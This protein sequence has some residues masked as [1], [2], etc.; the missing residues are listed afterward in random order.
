MWKLVLAQLL[1]AVTPVLLS[2]VKGFAVTFRDK[3]RKTDNP[4]DDVL[5]DLILGLL[6]VKEDD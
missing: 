5:A 2:S 3:A 4:W 1:G 6:G